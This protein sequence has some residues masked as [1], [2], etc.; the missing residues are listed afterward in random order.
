MQYGFSTSLTIYFIVWIA[1]LLFLSKKKHHHFFHSLK[2]IVLKFVLEHVWEMKNTF[3]IKK[4]NTDMDFWSLALVQQYNE[5]KE[6]IK[7]FVF[8]SPD[9]SYSE[10]HT[11][12]VVGIFRPF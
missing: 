6:N 12:F 5:F 11:F 4:T 10:K 1:F 2:A 8:S 3:I 7:I 9:I